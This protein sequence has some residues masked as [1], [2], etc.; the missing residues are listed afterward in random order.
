MKVSSTSFLDYYIYIYIYIYIYN[1]LLESNLIVNQ[2][3]ILTFKVVEN[4]SIVL[5]KLWIL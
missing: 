3:V 5:Y 4:L 2:Y 1:S